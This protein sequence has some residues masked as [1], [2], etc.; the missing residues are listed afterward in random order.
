[1]KYQQVSNL[2]N[3]QENKLSR[4]MLKMV[5]NYWWAEIKL[6]RERAIIKT[7]MLQSSLCD[8]CSAYIIVKSIITM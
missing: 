6:Q 8:Y 1:M 7:T 5:G 3:K 2:L 4:F